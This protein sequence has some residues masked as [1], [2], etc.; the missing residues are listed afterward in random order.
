MKLTTKTRAIKYSGNIISA[1]LG[2]TAWNFYQDAVDNKPLVVSLLVFA[3][4]C[5]TLITAII[6]NTIEENAKR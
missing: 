3:A 2:V 6:N 1:A 5:V 4:F